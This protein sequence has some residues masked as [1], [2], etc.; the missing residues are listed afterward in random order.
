MTGISRF[1]AI[2]KNITCSFTN[3]VTIFGDSPGKSPFLVKKLSLFLSKKN[4]GSYLFKCAPISI[5][6][7]SSTVSRTITM[8]IYVLSPK[9]I[10]IADARHYYPLIINASQAIRVQTSLIII[11]CS[12]FDDDK[13]G[14]MDFGEF[15]LATNCTSLSDPQAKV[16]CFGHYGDLCWYWWCSNF[17]SRYLTFREK[18]CDCAIL[19]P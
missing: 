1:S 3:I 16:R 8:C 7:H 18:S 19:V 5:G 12:V 15:I 2:T 14:T 13:N 4:L 10:P 11:L 6:T 17:T 9:L